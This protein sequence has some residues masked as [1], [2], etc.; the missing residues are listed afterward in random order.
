MEKIILR[1]TEKHLKY[2]AVIGKTQHW[3]ESPV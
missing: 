2:S 3:A 1:D